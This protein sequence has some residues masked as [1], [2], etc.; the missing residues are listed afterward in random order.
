L[1]SLD[2]ALTGACLGVG[3]SALFCLAALA[4]YPL[5]E[6]TEAHFSGLFY[7]SE[8]L[9]EFAA[10]LLVWALLSRRW[11]LVACTVLPLLINGSRISVLA[12][13]VALVYG[14]WPRGWRARVALI[15]TVVLALGAVLLYFTSWNHKLGSVALRAIFWLSTAF[16]ITPLGHGLGWFR[17]ANL[18]TE[19][20]HS[21]ALQALAEL[22]RGPDSEKRHPCRTRSLPGH[23][24]RD[25]R[26][27]SAP[28]PGLGVS[29]RAVGGLSGWRP[30]WPIPGST[31]RRNPSWCARSMVGRNPRPPCCPKPT[32][33]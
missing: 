18:S 24:R 9:T 26:L 8:V 7:N 10:P 19:F 3:V 4:G 32:A 1:E 27:V 21:D 5:A 33:R 28:C 29:G 31:W 22:G 15:G 6:Q 14:L 30:R 2:D 13:T 16:A 17:S 25:P 12:A 11:A 23:G 20:A